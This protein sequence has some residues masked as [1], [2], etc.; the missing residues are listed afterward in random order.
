M[1]CAVVL[2]GVLSYNTRENAFA[3]TATIT[4]NT[5]YIFNINSAS[6]I[7]GNTSTTAL[8]T[9]SMTLAGAFTVTFSDGNYI[10]GNTIEIGKGAKT[11]TTLGF[12]TVTLR[13]DSTNLFRLNWNNT[14]HFRSSKQI[15]GQY[16]F[17]VEGVKI[18]FTSITRTAGGSDALLQQALAFLA[19]HLTEISPDLTIIEAGY[20]IINPNYYS[21][22]SS[23]STLETNFRL[24][25]VETE[26]AIT[27]PLSTSGQAQLYDT[28]EISQGLYS[29]VYAR[30]ENDLTPLVLYNATNDVVNAYIIQILSDT[31]TTDSTYESLLMPVAGWD[32]LPYWAYTLANNYYDKGFNTNVISD[33]T[34]GVISALFSGLFGSIFAVEIFPNFPLY[35]FILIPVVFAILSLVLWLMRGR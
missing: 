6:T 8:S 30:Y 35:I 21:D 5:D 7:T 9:V 31:P 3:E 11:G 2:A 13:Q 1:L 33:S 22:F 34:S 26:S 4:P 10:T 32:V 25:Q 14:Q 19:P 24:Y 15:D 28:L 16:T 29:G 12:Q 20:Y 17:D 27:S 23:Y 18:V